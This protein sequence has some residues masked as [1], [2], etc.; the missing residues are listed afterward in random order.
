MDF[1]DLEA[2]QAVPRLTGLVLSPDGSRLVTSV[3]SLDAKEQAWVSALWEIDPTGARAARRLTR[4][5]KG[6]A[7]PAFTAEGDLLFVSARPD[8][9]SNEDDKPGLWLLPAAGAR[10][11]GS[12]AAPAVWP[13][14]GR[15]R[16]WW[17]L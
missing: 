8:A 12:A 5:G 7:A 2:F 14:R 6:E 16:T 1:P 3:A 11:A 17:W 13:V 15:R 10:R 4:S 9:G